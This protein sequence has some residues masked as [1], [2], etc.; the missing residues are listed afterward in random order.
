MTVTAADFDALFAP[1]AKPAPAQVVVDGPPALCRKCKRARQLEAGLCA[2]CGA[3]ELFPDDAPPVVVTQRTA[4]ITCRVCRKPAEVL[5]SAE[6][7]LCGYYREDIDRTLSHL[8]ELFN[9]AWHA[10]YNAT[11]RLAADLAHADE[12]VLRRWAAYQDAISAKDPRVA[13]AEQ[14]VRDG[15]VAGPFADL[16]RQYL[17]LRTAQRVHAEIT[18]H[19]DEALN[20]IE[21]AAPGAA[22]RYRLRHAPRLGE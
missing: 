21:A 18:K 15:E 8:R 22:D 7:L 17:E 20:E 4:R 19:I 14:R 1:L 6:G 2:E 9:G 13:E 16:V 3:A 10:L 12:A 11:A 5:I